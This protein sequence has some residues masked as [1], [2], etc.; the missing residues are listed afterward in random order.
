MVCTLAGDFSH[1]QS[2]EEPSKAKEDP[3][4]LAERKKEQAN[5]PFETAKGRAQDVLAAGQHMT[6]EAERRRYQERT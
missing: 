4:T 3:R 1:E 6:G 2:Q 5:G